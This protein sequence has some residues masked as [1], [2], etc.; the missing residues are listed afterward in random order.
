[1]NLKSDY[2]I[3]EIQDTTHT[4]LWEVDLKTMSLHWSRKTYE[5]HNIPES[6]E[7]DIEKA[8]SFYHDDD[9][10]IIKTAFE[11]CINYQRPYR[12]ILRI[13]DNDGNTVFV[14]ANGK[15]IVEN[16]KVIK[17]Y[18][19]FRNM[20]T[21]FNL[22]NK[23]RIMGK[24]L[25]E[26][27]RSLE[28]F[29]IVAHTDIRGKI[30]SVNENFCKISGYTEKELLGKDHRILNSGTHPKEFFHNLWDTILRGN[31]WNGTVCNKKKDG[32]LYWVETFIFPNKLEKEITSF[33]A[34]RFDITEK[35]NLQ[36]QLNEEIDRSTFQSQLA[37]IGEMSTG[38]SHEINNPLSI[39]Q[40]NSMIIE[41][42]CQDNEKVLKSV[43]SINKAIKRIS[44]IINGLRRLGTKSQSDDFKTVSLS[45][46]FNDTFEFCLE[47]LQH[48]C[49]KVIYDKVDPKIKIFCNEVK[50]SQIFINLIN[51]AKDAIIDSESD[52]K[53]IKIMVEDNDNDV[54]IHIIDSGPGIPEENKSRIMEKFFTTKSVSHGNGLGLTLVNNFVKEING[55][56]YLNESFSNTCFTIEI[57]KAKD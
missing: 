27:K 26:Y 21:H 24:E 29:F 10:E 18:G 6:E 17:I 25:S 56:F 31:A 44:R 55:K 16:G 9:Q 37:A 15:P 4:G 34:I 36:Q 2:F 5:I 42:S 8:I 13:V 12:K 14:E 32:S 3:E 30:I 1:M 20:N 48:K 52:E 50:V 33:T 51:N 53:W 23:K 7:I 47:A 45:Q 46:I 57:P 19:T 43:S 35:M 38:I 11:E 49:V 41:K 40:G 28:Q 39:I 22:I 54:I